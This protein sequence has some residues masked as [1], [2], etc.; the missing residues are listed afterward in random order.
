MEERDLLREYYKEYANIWDKKLGLDS[1]YKE[2]FEELY[3][4]VLVMKVETYV[5]SIKTISY[6]KEREELL[7]DL[8]GSVSFFA[9]S[10]DEEYMIWKVYEE[11]HENNVKALENRLFELQS[12][13]NTD[14]R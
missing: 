2:R 12:E 6:E 9:E 10:V 7:Q 4:E 1:E 3:Y 11:E 13:R 8:A 14:F 5:D